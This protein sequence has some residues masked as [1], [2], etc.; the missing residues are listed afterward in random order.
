VLAEVAGRLRLAVRASD[1]VCRLGDDRFAVLCTEMDAA[2]A[3]EVVAQRVLASLSVPFE[4]DEAVLRL[5][6][7]IG[8]SVAAAGTTPSMLLG[9]ADIAMSAAKQ[10]GGDRFAWYEPR[11]PAWAR[12]ARVGSP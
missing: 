9:E 2:D 12:S 4:M 5:T 10:R 6:V 3:A 1:S 8:V 11:A 7:S